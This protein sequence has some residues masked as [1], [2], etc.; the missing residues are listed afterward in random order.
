MLMNA[1]QT[2]LRLRENGRGVMALSIRAITRIGIGALLLLTIATLAASLW[3][4][5]AQTGDAIVSD[6]VGA[7]RALTERMVKD[8]SLAQFA[9]DRTAYAQNIKDSA[10]AFDTALSLLLDGG[11]GAIAGRAYS[12]SGST[13]DF[14]AALL[15]TQPAWTEMQGA[16]QAALE[17]SSGAPAQT[18]MLRVEEAARILDARLGVA[19]DVY[20]ATTA[21]HAARLAWGIAALFA[22]GMAVLAMAYWWFS[23]NVFVPVDA[24]E[25]ATHRMVAGDL[26]RP[27]S[28]EAAHELERL[29]SALES[30]RRQLRAHGQ[31]QES[32]SRLAADLVRADDAE[33]VVKVTSRVVGEDLGATRAWVRMPDGEGNLALAGAFDGIATNGGKEPPTRLARAAIITCPM[34]QCPSWERGSAHGCAFILKADL[35]VASSFSVQ[36]RAGERP[37]GTLCV[38][39]SEKRSWTEGEMG[40]VQHAAEEASAALARIQARQAVLD[41]A[42]EEVETFRQAAQAKDN[43]LSITSHELRSPIHSIVGYAELL[44]TKDLPE[45]VRQECLQY[46]H[47]E[48]KRLTNMVDDLLDFARIQSS[49]VSVNIKTL[50]VDD[51]VQEAVLAVQIK[52]SSHIIEVQ[53]PRDLPAV[54]GDN[55]KLYQVLLNLLTNAIKY[56]PKGGKVIVGAH[57][58]PDYRYVDVW[59]KDQ[60]LGL[61]PEDRENLFAPFFRVK[62]AETRDIEGTGLGLFIVKRYMESMQGDISVE[63]KVNAGSTFTIKLPVA[64]DGGF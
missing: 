7:Q 19:A 5:S 50:Q 37:L 23:R 61:T 22:T 45:A 46:I 47:Q 28:V 60:G 39:S 8:A 16:L 14:R 24:L 9:E 54:R 4:S 55:N 30:M 52:S 21:A 33:Q 40:L 31:E 17:G 63:S 53:L 56:S 15:G 1:V 59:V 43:A 62:R 13:H 18:Q 57:S 51:V 20:Q 35:G 3:L 26:D 32:L 64:V 34:T 44:L 58:D 27:I 42:K 36:M 48:G 38:L 11:Q 10:A 49:G 29:A 2:A 25:S 6:M 41:T 12:L